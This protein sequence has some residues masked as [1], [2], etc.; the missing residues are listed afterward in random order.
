MSVT[1]DVIIPTP[2][3]STTYP[4]NGGQD[5]NAIHSIVQLFS[6]IWQVFFK[7]RLAVSYKTLPRIAGKAVRDC[8]TKDTC[9]L[10]IIQKYSIA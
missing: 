2:G 7:K 9:K 5:S 6:A 8:F 3:A 10:R 1:A 4:Y